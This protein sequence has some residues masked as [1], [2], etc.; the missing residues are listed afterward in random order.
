MRGAAQA[1]PRGGVP[2][3]P[4][5]QLVVAEAE[6]QPLSVD[7]AELE[8][9]RHFD[10]AWQYGPCTGEDPEGPEAHGGLSPVTH[11]P[12]RQS[13]PCPILLGAVPRD[14]GV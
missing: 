12:P 4:E 7:E 9:L 10:L 13:K 3:R 14:W 5:E 1:Q 6:I 2:G 8:L 11:T